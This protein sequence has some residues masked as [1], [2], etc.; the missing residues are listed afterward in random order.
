[1]ADENDSAYLRT[2]IERIL[3]VETND[4][5]FEAFCNALI[6]RELESGAPILSTSASWDL[7]RDGVGLGAA[8][9]I[10]VCTSLRD[11]VD[12]KA[13]DDIERVTSTTGRVVRLYVC[14]SQS[15]SEH[16]KDRLQ[17][18]L[19]M[20]TENSIP[21]TCLPANYLSQFAAKHMDLVDRHYGAEKADVLRV[22]TA[23]PADSTELRGLRIALM[24]TA[25]E[26]SHSIRSEVYS[27]ALLE[28]LVDGVPRTIAVVS[29][30][31]GEYLALGRSIATAAVQPHLSTLIAKGFVEE[32]QP[33]YTITAAGTTE[34]K[35][36][37]ADGAGRLLA[38][39]K[40]VREALENS[41]GERIVDDEFARIWGVFEERTANYFHSRGENLV[42]EVASLLSGDEKVQ[43]DRSAMAYVEELAVAVGATSSLP[44]RQGELVQATKDLFTDRTGPA[45]AWLI[46]VAAHFI[47][48]CAL[49]LEHSSAAAL[50]KL[51]SRTRLVLDTDVVLSLLGEGEPEH[52]GVKQI[53][54]RWRR[55]GGRLLVAVP[56]LEEAARHAWIAQRDFDYVSHLLPGSAEDRL[57]LI[58]NAFVRSFAE[59]MSR[60]QARL[61]QWGSYI[62]MY[63]GQHEYDWTKVA[64]VLR[65]EYKIDQLPGRSLA[66]ADFETEV[67]KYLV[68]RATEQQRVT[69]APDPYIQDKARRD[70]VLYVDLV[71]YMDRLRE[72]DP[73]S[74]CLLVSSAKRLV[75]A[76]AHF[77][78]GQ[79]KQIVVSIG[80][81][82]HML[83]LLPDVHLGL[84]AMKAF[85][86][87]ERRGQ[88]SSDLERVLLR[89]IRGSSEMSLP[90]AKRGGLTRAIRRRIVE[91]AMQK[92]ERAP[93]HVLVARYERDALKPENERQTI[94][95]LSKA[96]DEV[97]VDPKLRGRM[98]ELQKEVAQLRQELQ[99]AQSRRNK[100]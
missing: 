22:T 98:A 85:L 41:M 99:K 40:D 81:M 38:M 47:A 1:M 82:L 60:K 10:Y 43:P 84:S 45:A 44:Q 28:I 86:F 26:D 75:A 34:V 91:D 23:D 63:V 70:S 87:D 57:H 88:F 13:I 3:N 67:R 32:K 58:S 4:A 55:L 94:Q 5:R 69:A 49:G 66:S 93:E 65:D 27:S 36:R 33:T 71:D 83:S 12:G 9:G 74:T 78:R 59:L 17:G 11:D 2:I 8:R 73:S 92:G 56:V 30:E 18:A 6:S 29:K 35:K 16:G 90:F 62:D 20:L 54:E 25:A 39:R 77:Q 61:T 52:D 14:T 24:S 89:V 79:E 80:A 46:R 100:G 31:L 53:A 51:F 97:G 21:I 68:E 37:S 76:E 42:A 48:A 7:G 96:L 72:N 64:E 50:Q 95:M 15:L 19:E